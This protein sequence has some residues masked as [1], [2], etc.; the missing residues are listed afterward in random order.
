[1]TQ[2]H[3]SSSLSPYQ[4]SELVYDMVIIVIQ[5]RK[6]IYLL[7]IRPQ[8]LQCHSFCFLVMNI[9]ISTKLSM[10]ILMIKLHFYFACNQRPHLHYGQQ[11]KISLPHDE[12]PFL[13]FL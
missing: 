1:M 13:L 11:L 10:V 3:S 5:T 12:Y 4:T 7:K 8:L 6:G 9:R 2:I